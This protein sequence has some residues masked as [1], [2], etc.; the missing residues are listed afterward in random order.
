MESRTTLLGGRMGWLR[1]DNAGCFGTAHCFSI[2]AGVSLAETLDAGGGSFL[3]QIRHRTLERHHKIV[4]NME[5]V[6]TPRAF[7]KVT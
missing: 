5:I 7:R 6:E 4:E 3:S 2:H 1:A